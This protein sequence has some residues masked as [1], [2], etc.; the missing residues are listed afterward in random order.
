MSINSEENKR[1]FR[2]SLRR[3]EA[4]GP[5]YLKKALEALRDKMVYENI[6]DETAFWELCDDLVEN[7]GWDDA[8]I[9]AYF[10]TY[11]LENNT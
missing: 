1:F 9:L 6:M 8:H 3:Y 4:F 2:Y 5:S 10:E 11:N 7:N